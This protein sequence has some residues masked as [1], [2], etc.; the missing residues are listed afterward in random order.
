MPFGTIGAERVKTVSWEKNIKVISET[1]PKNCV[2]PYLSPFDCLIDLNALDENQCKHK[3]RWQS[4][5]FITR[6]IL[7][8]Y[9]AN[10]T[11]SFFV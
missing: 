10:F 11:A 6:V 3:Y 5:S 1:V 2:L 9:F 7:L 8:S 4:K